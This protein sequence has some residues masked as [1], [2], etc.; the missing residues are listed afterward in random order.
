MQNLTTDEDITIDG[1]IDDGDIL[2][3]NTAFGEKSVLILSGGEYT[4]AFEY[5]DP[6]SVFW[7]LQP[8]DNV[9]R[10][11]AASEGENAQCRLYYYH[12]YSGL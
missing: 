1:T 3:I 7:K 10:Y 4:N 2:I 6:D 8:G 12:R 5:V 9:V 11:T